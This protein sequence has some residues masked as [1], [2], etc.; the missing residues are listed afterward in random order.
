[1]ANERTTALH[2]EL[3][4]PARASDQEQAGPGSFQ[5]Y[6]M[7]YHRSQDQQ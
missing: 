7:A 3:Q 4:G 6:Q 1:M 2:K 5:A